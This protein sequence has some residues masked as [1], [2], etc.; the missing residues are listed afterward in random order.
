MLS[1]LTIVS[2]FTEIFAAG[3]LIS[4]GL[5]FLWMFLITRRS[6]DLFFGLV[7]LSIFSYVAAT[8]ASQLMFNLGRPLA[9]LIIA[10]KF[11]YAGILLSAFFLW[12]FIIVK[13]EIKWRLVLVG[14][15]L[16]LTGYFLFQVVNATVNL[17]YREGII[18][19]IVQFSYWIPVKPLFSLMLGLLALFS[20]RSAVTSAGGRRTLLF[21]TTASAVIFLLALASTSFYGR[22]GEAGYLLTS[23][24]LTL[25]SILG[26]L[27]GELIPPESPE[28]SGRSVSCGP[29]AVQAR[30]D[31]CAADHHPF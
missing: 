6:K 22:S 25:I 5:S 1:T 31:L 9:E 27:L 21:Y 13:F 12:L 26:L 15:L 11:V 29:D 2:I 24:V 30:V 19:P 14:A 7:F 10:Q 18:E 8:I 23:W 17:V 20:L 28:A 4:G 3:I 16:A